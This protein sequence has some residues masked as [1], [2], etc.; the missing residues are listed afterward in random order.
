MAVDSSGNILVAE[1]QSIRRVTPDGFI[2]TLAGSL[3]P[4]FSG[5]GGP[6]IEARL[7]LA[8]SVEADPDG[9]IYIADFYNHRIRKVSPQGIINTIAGS[10]A[11]DQ[12]S[13][14]GGG[15]GGDGGP[16]TAA[17]LRY[18]QGI[19][20]DTARNLYIA[21]SRNHRIRR[22]TPNGTIETF[23]GK[24]VAGFA[25]DGG[26]ATQAELRFP[27][28]VEVDAEGN[29]LIADTGNHRIRR[30][31]PSGIIQTIAG[32]GSAGFSGDRGPATAAQLDSPRGIAA[33]N[34]G[35]IYVSDSNNHQ[36]RKLGRGRAS[37]Q[38][39]PV[40]SWILPSNA[41]ARGLAGAF[42]TTDLTVA[43]TSGEEVAATIQFLGNNQDGRAGPS[44]IVSLA[45]GKIVSYHDVLANL[46][47]VSEDWGALRITANSPSLAIHGQT[48]TA[49]PTGGSYGH[50]VLASAPK[51]LV[52]NGLQH[53]IVGIREDVFF[54]TNLILANA[55]DQPLEVD[56]S[57]LSGAGLELGARRVSLP[58][59]GMTQL[60]QVVRQLGIGQNLETAQLILSTPTPGGSFA[61]Y[62]ALI[63]NVTNDPRTLSAQWRAAEFPYTWILPSSARAPGIAGAFYTTDLTLSNTAQ[64]ALHF[65]LKF[66]GN[67]RNGLVGPSKDL[68]LEADQSLRLADV[69]KSVF[70]LDQDYGAIRLAG[71][72]M[73]SSFGPGV[74]VQAQTST[75]APGGGTFGQSVPAASRTDE[76]REGT[77]RSI[78]GVTENAAFRTNLVLANAS[79]AQA[80]VE[81]RLLNAEGILLG[82]K[83]IILQPLGMTQLNRVVREF[84]VTGD[85]SNARLV[86]VNSDPLVGVTAYAAIID[87]VTNDPRTLLPQ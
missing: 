42:F 57:L 61:A 76:V 64:Y 55:T 63:D 15:Y 8:R 39:Q 9:N 72:S 7:S 84:A 23:A 30:V 28:A 31:T 82:T 41:R 46:F 54:R 70:G 35:A 77:T 85:V 22:V 37:S 79:E 38:I 75:P 36:F 16:A 44:K 45:A 34:T 86:I 47:G 27:G 59:L 26:Q 62:A 20:L 25:G 4:G 67:N 81:L 73:N 71:N 17:L 3:Q 48:S 1:E 80:E 14:P 32:V 56:L 58:P 43:N 5:D 40:F 29:V 78:V 19:A 52:R 49:G 6:A 68:T 74:V 18:P 66:L 12:G 83:R 2:S 10:G 11:V 53:A 69:L 51:D 65:S 60:T 24:G 50:S 87:N 33:D 13:S 21:D